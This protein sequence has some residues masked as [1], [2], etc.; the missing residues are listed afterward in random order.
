MK[1]AGTLPYPLLLAGEP[2]TAARLPCCCAIASD[3]MRPSLDPGDLVEVLPLRGPLRAGQVVLFLS[4]NGE[5]VVHRVVARSGNGWRTRG[6][7]NADLDTAVLQRWAIVGRVVARWHD[8]RR[9]RLWEHRY[10]PVLI[11]IWRRWPFWR[12][13]LRWLLRLPS[14]WLARCALERGR[15]LHLKAYGCDELKLLWAGWA[16]ARYDALDRRWWLRWPLTA[17]PADERS[18][19][20]ARRLGARAAE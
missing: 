15:W 19:R 16:L 5:M 2:I 3:S 7:A 11:G 20:L 4:A 10:L 17:L 6:D 12:R 14:L 9:S 8:G 1:R 18:A 13:I